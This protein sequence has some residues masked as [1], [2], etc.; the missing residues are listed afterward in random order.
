[1]KNKFVTMLWFCLSLFIITK[2][3]VHGSAW[4]QGAENLTTE[5]PVKSKVSIN[6]PKE[7]Y[8]YLVTIPEN[9]TLNYLEKEHPFQIGFSEEHETLDPRYIEVLLDEVPSD[10]KI[11]LNYKSD[12]SS[13]DDSSKLIFKLKNS[14]DVL[15]TDSNNRVALFSVTGKIEL[16]DQETV[17]VCVEEEDWKKVTRSGNYV[18]AINF[19]IQA[20]EESSGGDAN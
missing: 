8:E 5:A 18:G 6:F 1:M 11:I 9:I 12:D 10:G 7:G 16:K 4:A 15:I 14:S 13:S 3:L 19:N 17:K 20:Q 2:P